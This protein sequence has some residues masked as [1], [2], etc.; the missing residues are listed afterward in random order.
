MNAVSGRGFS[1]ALASI[2]STPE[3]LV[4]FH[5]TKGHQLFYRQHSSHPL[6]QRFKAIAQPERVALYPHVTAGLGAVRR[7]LTLKFQLGLF[8]NPYVDEDAAG[9]IVGNPA[10]QAKADA[11]QLAALVAFENRQTILKLKKGTTEALIGRRRRRAGVRVGGRESSGRGECRGDPG[12][13]PRHLEHLNRCRR[14][15]LMRRRS[16]RRCWSCT[17]IDL[18]LVLQAIADTKKDGEKVA[19]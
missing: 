19:V 8:E 11:A 9:R 16:G 17:L 6:K 3:R 5:F 15:S 10:T 14:P 12:G 18:P 7:I 2:R 13:C 1:I 4:P